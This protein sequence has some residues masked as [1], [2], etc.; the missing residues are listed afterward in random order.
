MFAWLL[1]SIL[2]IVGWGG[3]I[4]WGNEHVENV[5]LARNNILLEEQ[6]EGPLQLC[7]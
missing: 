2:S 3:F 4:G 6:R 5:C 1:I 7:R